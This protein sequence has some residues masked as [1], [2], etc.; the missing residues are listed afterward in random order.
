M[1]NKKDILASSVKVNFLLGAKNG[2]F[3][4]NEYSIQAQFC[5]Q[6]ELNLKMYVHTPY[7]IMAVCKF[8]NPPVS[9]SV[10]DKF[11]VNAPGA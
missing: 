5:Q 11:G 7:T 2:N 6:L 10:V 9:I 3:K 4:L 1:S 8:V